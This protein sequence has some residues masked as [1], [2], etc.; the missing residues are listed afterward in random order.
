LDTEGIVKDSEENPFVNYMIFKISHI[1]RYKYNRQVFLE[2]HTLRLRPRNDCSQKLH[3]FAIEVEPP[4]VGKSDC[5][6]LEGNDT[7]SLWFEGLH[8]ELTISTSSVVETLRDNP[9]DF[10]VQNEEAFNLP[11]SYPDYYKPFL[12]P[13]QRRERINAE[14]DKFATHIS[15]EANNQTLAFL[16]TLSLY[17]CN[18]FEHIFRKSGNPYRPEVTLAKK[19]G[20]CR[21]MVVLF[22][23]ACRALG[24]AARFVSGYRDGASTN[25]EKHLHAWAEVYIPGGG[26]RGFDPSFG[27]AV[28][29]THV[30]LASGITPESAAPISGTYRGSQSTSRLEFEINIQTGRQLI[31]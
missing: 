11:L 6:D 9:F 3:R 15:E 2:P 24:I 20:A 5:V 27:L 17:I 1:T 14:V 7:I 16:R 21:D 29:N 30:A 18:N 13:Y 8:N 19:K 12:I 25:T 26:W 28:S 22:I 4:Q 23:D 10:I 31:D